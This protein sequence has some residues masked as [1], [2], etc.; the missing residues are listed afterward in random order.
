MIRQG[1]GDRGAGNPRTREFCSSETETQRT[2]FALLII[3]AMYGPAKTSKSHGLSC[4]A[5]ESKICTVCA[6]ASAWYLMYVTTAS[7]SFCSRACSTSGWVYM[8]SLMCV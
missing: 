2:C 8:S 7:V 4:A 5:Q 6:P 3:W 1:E